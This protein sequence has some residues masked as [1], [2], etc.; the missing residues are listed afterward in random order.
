[1]AGEGDFRFVGARLADATLAGGRAWLA[2]HRLPPESVRA[3]LE[4]LFLRRLENREYRALVIEQAGTPIGHLTW[5]DERDIAA[6]KGALRIV[7][8][9]AAP[10]WE[11]HGIASALSAI[12]VREACEVGLPVLGDVAI[13]GPSDWQVVT[14]LG[15][16]GW[17]V[18]GAVIEPP[19]T[20]PE[21][22][23]NGSA[24]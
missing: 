23:R 6:R 9:A 21:T 2:Q 17:R 24:L 1:M 22:M 19:E 15:R 16:T 20:I 13:G 11:R 18:Y 3:A 4:Q 12:I 14:R 7:D 5:G 8:A 10:G